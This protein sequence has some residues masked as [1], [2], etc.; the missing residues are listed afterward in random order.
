MAE[1]I[2]KSKIQI[3]KQA[4]QAQQR[5]ASINEA[6]RLEK[7]RQEWLQKMRIFERASVSSSSAAGAGGGGNKRTI[8]NLLAFKLNTFTID[9][10]SNGN[11][12]ENINQPFNN[13]T[14]FSSCSDDD[15]YTYYVTYNT[16]TEKVIFGKLDKKTLVRTD[17]DTTNLNEQTSRYPASLY[18]EGNGNFIYLDDFF[19]SESG[20]SRIYRISQ[21]GQTI[22]LLSTQNN[23]TIWPLN[24]FEY[25]GQT[26]MTG[27]DT[28][29][30]QIDINVNDS[31]T[32][33][34]YTYMNVNTL[35]SG[36]TS[37]KVLFVLD[38]KLY[39]NE[40][41]SM[42]YFF[43]KTNSNFHQCFAKLNM[44]DFS[45]DYIFSV[46]SDDLF[47]TFDIL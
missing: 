1:P 21:D 38:T 39:N 43:D 3:Q 30:Y 17:I 40:I 8:F 12:N 32:L 28:A 36:T 2:W 6:Q 33:L 23:Q 35:P 27:I 45:L 29:I 47:V 13:N 42:V 18:Y 14:V 46:D 37:A 41:Y 5:Q 25:N 26:Y 9:F 24:V 19:E 34:D 16:D 15:N 10:I 7:A 20:S 44:N 31:F 22:N 4:Q 11:I